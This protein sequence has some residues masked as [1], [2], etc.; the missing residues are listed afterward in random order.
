MQK[1]L[2]IDRD[3]TLIEGPPSGGQIDS[4]DKLHFYPNVITWLSRIA[5]ELDY[6]FVMVTNQNGLGTAVFTQE[7]FSPTQD[8]ML[9]VLKGEGIIFEN[10]I[11][12]NSYP[13]DNS[14]LRKPRIG[15][16]YD[17]IHNPEIDMQ[18]SFVIGD[19]ITDVQFAKNLGCKAIFLNPDNPRG[20]TELTDTIEEL[21]TNWTALA[22]TSWKDVYTFLKNIQPT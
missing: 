2:F 7:M 4:F 17:Y 19:R 3:G 16:M 6:V 5:H 9:K 21:K 10:I 15:R 20:Q 11:V 1:Y 8:F 12:D 13:T 22:S 18:H 14:P